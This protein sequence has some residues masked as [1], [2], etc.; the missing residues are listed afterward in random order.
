MKNYTI[1]GALAIIVAALLW[2]LDGTFLRPQ[3]YT[4]PSVFLVFLEHTLGF[5]ILIPFLFIF[6]SQL[7]TISKKQWMTIF[8]VALFGGALGTTFMTKALFLTGFKD[9]SVVILLQ[10]FQPIFA[11]TLAAM[12][13]R[14]RFPKRFYA[15]ATI[16]VLAGYFVT[17]KDPFTI[18]KVTGAA[19]LMILYSLLAAFAWGSSTTFGKYSLKNINYGLLAA[20]RF[21]LTI[22]IMALPALYYYHGQLTLVSARQWTTLAIIVFTSGA[23]AMWLY[24]FGLKKIPASLATLCELSWPVSAIIF[25]YWLNHNVLSWSQLLGT[26]VLIIAVYKVT[27][28]NRPR[29]ITGTVEAGLGQGKNLGTKTAN[30]NI[31]L[32]NKLPKGLYTC[33][34]TVDNNTHSGLLY[35]G[36]N[37][38]SQND[39]LEAHIFDF[40]ND[41]YGQKITVTTGRYLRLPKK[42][43]DPKD[44]MAQIQK[45]VQTPIDNNQKGE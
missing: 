19:G 33:E 17:F 30:L 16:A 42:F 3:L 45:D 36:Y 44:L 1:I 23:A 18:N 43:K 15:Y 6:K 5:I 4:L 38:I 24:Y 29:T 14:E 40:A 32:A 35:Y 37:S 27:M 2:S 7:K 22:L 25:D 13:L 10:K 21:G 11:I 20:L 41:I 12:F 9:I 39:C 28:L 31:A 26:A 8:W 34:V